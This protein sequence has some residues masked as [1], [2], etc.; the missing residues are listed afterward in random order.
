MELALVLELSMHGPTHDLGLV[1][2]EPAL[3]EVAGVELVAGQSQ[4]LGVGNSSALVH[5][6]L[7]GAGTHQLHDRVL[8]VALPVLVLLRLQLVVHLVVHRV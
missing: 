3:L 8:S 5:Q 6:V 7:A 4:S 2:L 1:H